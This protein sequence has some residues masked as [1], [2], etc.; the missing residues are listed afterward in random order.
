MARVVR[1][2][3]RAGTKDAKDL[4]KRMAAGDFG[5]DGAPD[6]RLA[7]ERLARKP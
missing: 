1:V 7:L 6:A 5:F 4:L 2:L 3:E